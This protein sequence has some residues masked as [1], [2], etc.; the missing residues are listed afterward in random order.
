MPSATRHQPHIIH[1][2]M[3]T[4]HLAGAVVAF[5]YGMNPL[6]EVLFTVR[7]P[8][9]EILP[10]VGSLFLLTRPSFPFP[11]NRNHLQVN[12]GCFICQ[13]YLPCVF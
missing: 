7:V 13:A 2:E 8:L 6:G 5:L 3:S 10:G 1:A 9:Q 11:W 12:L 4:R